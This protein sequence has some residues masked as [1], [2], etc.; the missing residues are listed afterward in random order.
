MNKAIIHGIYCSFF[1]LRQ[2]III[3]L[4]HFNCD[5]KPA[6]CSQPA[7]RDLHRW[8]LPPKIDPQTAF[9]HPK[10]AAEADRPAA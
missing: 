1:V 8:S 6:S 10:A 7:L 5:C 4:I 3:S 9:Q 2:H